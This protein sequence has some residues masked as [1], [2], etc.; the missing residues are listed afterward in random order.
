MFSSIDA[1]CDVYLYYRTPF[2][3]GSLDHAMNHSVPDRVPSHVPSSLVHDFDLYAVEVEGGDYHGAL[4]RLHDPG[5]PD[6]FWTP[7]NGGHWVA[8]RGDDI[9]E[10]FK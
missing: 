2:K 5:I 8:T 10:I 6:I 9:Y 1:D 7:R 4:K 3:K